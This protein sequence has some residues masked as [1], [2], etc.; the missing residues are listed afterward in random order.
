MKFRFYRQKQFDGGMMYAMPQQP[1]QV[2]IAY[3]QQPQQPV[4]M[5]YPQ[6]QPQK[7]EKMSTGKKIALG[8]GGL[9]TAAGT[10]YA[11]YRGHLGAGIQKHLGTMAHKVGS[12]LGWNRL[13]NSGATT[14]YAA[15]G[16]E[17]GA[18]SKAQARDVQRFGLD[19]LR[20]KEGNLSMKNVNKFDEE[21]MANR[22]SRQLGLSGDDVMST[23]SVLINSGSRTSRG[24]GK[25]I[26][27]NITTSTNYD[28]KDG[29]I[30][31]YGEN[32]EKKILRDSDGNKYVYDSKK[33]V[34]KEYK[35]EGASS[36]STSSNN[37][38]KEQLITKTEP[39]IRT[40]Q[41]IAADKDHIKNWI[42]NSGDG[43]RRGNKWKMSKGDL[44]VLNRHKND[45]GAKNA[46]HD[47]I[48]NDNNIGKFIMEEDA[49]GNIIRFEKFKPSTAGNKEQRE[50]ALKRLSEN[51][52]IDANTG[53]LSEKGYKRLK[54]SGVITEADNKLHNDLDSTH[55]F[56]VKENENGAKE[57]YLKEKQ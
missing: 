44:E 24:I 39:K 2:Q 51:G 47:Y 13:A 49:N 6:Q 25:D 50:H 27:K 19:S 53:Q 9:A 12:G 3:P 34:A 48:N 14:T 11:G 43:D 21:A 10:A 46:I 36:S 45:E 38:T 7:E 33:D 1:Q 28:T 56:E 57:Y 31:R 52:E 15:L 30:Y 29:Q 35:E 18:F 4:M 8:L 32:G 37:T 40:E 41:D 20:N 42:D 55:S 26:D 54:N 17:A 16:R 5:V 23:N 22:T